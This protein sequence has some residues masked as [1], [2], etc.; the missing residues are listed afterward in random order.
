MARTF[1]DVLKDRIGYFLEHHERSFRTEIILVPALVIAIKLAID[2]LPK[3]STAGKIFATI[4]LALVFY[5]VGLVII[6]V[7]GDAFAHRIARKIN[8][9]KRFEGYFLQNRGYPHR[10]RAIARIFFDHKHLF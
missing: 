1:S 4:G 8:R 7:V 9:L 5:F 10:E 6:I 3:W 2:V